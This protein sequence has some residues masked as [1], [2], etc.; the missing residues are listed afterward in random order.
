MAKVKVHSASSLTTTRVSSKNQIT[1]PVAALRAAAMGPGTVVTV[2]V[3]GPGRIIVRTIDDA[4]DAYVGQLPG[5]WP[6]EA[7]DELRDE[8]A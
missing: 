5:I 3:D 7:L 8:W 2:E 1:L 6:A 4:L